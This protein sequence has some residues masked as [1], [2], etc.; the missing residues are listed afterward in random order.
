[1]TAAWTIRQ[2]FFPPDNESEKFVVKAFYQQTN[3]TMLDSVGKNAHWDFPQTINH[4]LNKFPL[5]I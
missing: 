1:L 3:R 2:L 5:I 4:Q